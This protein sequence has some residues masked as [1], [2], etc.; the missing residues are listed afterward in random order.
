MAQTESDP[1]EP[2]QLTA[3][4]AILMTL[5]G[6]KVFLLCVGFWASRRNQDGVE[7]YLGGR[8]LGPWVAALSSY[9]YA[10]SA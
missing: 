1:G 9:A 3:S 8:A 10:S 7:F 2:V 5:I 6:Y 4:T